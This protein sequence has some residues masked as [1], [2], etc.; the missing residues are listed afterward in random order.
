MNMSL[1]EPTIDGAFG[2]VK[3]RG[4]Y[5]YKEI[6]DA[7]SIDELRFQSKIKGYGITADDFMVKWVPLSIAAPLAKATSSDYDIWLEVATADDYDVMSSTRWN[8]LSNVIPLGMAGFNWKPWRRVESVD[9]TGRFFKF[10]IIAESYNPNVNVRLVSSVVEIDVLERIIAQ[11]D[12]Q[13]TNAAGGLLVSFNPPFRSVPALAINVDGNTKAIN[14]ELVSK[15]NSQ[16]VVR[17]IDITTG[18]P[19][20]GQIDVSAL[21]WGKIRTSSL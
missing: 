17:L 12:L 13:V 5:N 8:P 16:A 1:G 10:R 15:S 11:N 19:T 14:Y 4:V 3:N 18:T 21:G 7:G 6:F 20:T 2:A 9:L